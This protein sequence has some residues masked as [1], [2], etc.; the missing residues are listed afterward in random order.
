MKKLETLAGV[1]THTHTSIFTKRNKIGLNCTK[2]S[3]VVLESN[4]KNF[5]RKFIRNFIKN[6]IRKLIRNQIKDSKFKRTINAFENAI[7]LC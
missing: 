1:H 3:V 6:L 4:L 5:I 2:K 7:F